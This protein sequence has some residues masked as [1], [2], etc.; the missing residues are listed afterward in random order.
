MITVRGYLLG[1]AMLSLVAFAPTA[2]QAEDYSPTDSA[3]P[4][5]L[6]SYPVHAVGKGIETLV[7]RPVTWFVSRPKARYVFGKTSNPRKDDYTG[8]FDL[9]QRS[10]Y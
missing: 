4:F 8:D 2:A 5:R 9:Y 6:I 3:H 7:T 10:S 1:A